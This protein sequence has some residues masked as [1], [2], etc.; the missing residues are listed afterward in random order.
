MVAHNS[1]IPVFHTIRCSTFFLFYSKTW[2]GLPHYQNFSCNLG[3]HRD[4]G[5]ML[6]NQNYRLMSNLNSSRKAW[7]PIFLVSI[8]KYSTGLDSISIPMYFSTKT[9]NQ[10]NETT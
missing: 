9:T 5:N 4:N 10:I 8:M 1:M 7:M 3:N 2:T 6:I